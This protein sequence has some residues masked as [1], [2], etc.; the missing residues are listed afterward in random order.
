MHFTDSHCHLADPAL[1]DRLSEIWALAAGQGVTRFIVPATQRSDW[2]EVV[3]LL[4]LNTLSD[5]RVHIALGIHPWFAE[6]IQPQDFAGLER[7]LQ[8]HPQAWVGETGLDFMV[9]RPS[10]MQKQQ[11]IEAFCRQL[12]LAQKLKRPVIV[13]NVKATAAI[14]EAVKQTG[15]TQGGI[16]HAFSGSVE[17][18]QILLRCSFKIGIGSLLLN[19]K[20]KKVRQVVAKLD[21]CDM[22]LETDSPFMLPNETNT[23]ANVRRIAEIAAELRG[24]GLA[25]IACKTEENISKLLK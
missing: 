21:L 23:P 4:T 16:A 6:N 18:A 7:L 25:E 5:K 12:E 17:E 14:A 3:Q 13:H 20:A 2:A 10:E 19:P 24:V 1:R 9:G 22:V 8:Q 15:F 11:Q